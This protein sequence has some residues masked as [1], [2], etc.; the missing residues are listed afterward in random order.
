M[1]I[2]HIILTSQNGGAEEVFIN[3]IEACE[4]LGHENL[5]IIKND[6]P[7][8]ERLKNIKCEIKKT[9][10]IF[11][12]YDFLAIC[13]IKKFLKIFDADI[14]FCH[15][16]KS[17]ALTRKAIAKIKNKKIKQI[18]VN[19]SDNVK[20]SIGSDIVISVNKKIRQ[21]T[22][23]LGQKSDKS[24]VIS[25][26]IEV[27]EF[28]EFNNEIDFSKK[29]KIV[30]GLIGRFDRTKGFDYVIKS[31]KLLNNKS[32]KKFILKI[33]GDGY[34]KNELEELVKSEKIEDD[35]QFCGWIKD[36]NQ[37]FSDVDIFC[38]PSLNETFGIVVLEAM[39][40]KKP[41]I[42]TNCDGPMEILENEIDGLI[43]DRN[44]D[45]LSQNISDAVLKLVNNSNFAN[46]MV[47]NSYQKLHDKY[48][49]QA[50]EK[51]IIKIIESLQN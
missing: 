18:S 46:K 17:S 12:Y 51:N 26:A 9:K 1:K 24:F 28:V 19:H 32:D 6:A 27:G 5:V 10:N 14:V 7:Y 31:L 34:F 47:K 38:L 22:I 37:F 50:L 16:G 49:Y 25:N 43:I 21:K 13:N 20:R 48:S 40:Y 30:I 39:K 44:S 35:I 36:K 42:A 33:A 15:I 41:I 45:K 4:K 8:F 11:G 2:A 23:E 29:E 3:Y